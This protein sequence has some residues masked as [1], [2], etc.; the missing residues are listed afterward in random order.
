MASNVYED[1]TPAPDLQ[2]KQLRHLVWRSLFLQ[3]SFNYERMQACGWLYSILPGLRHIHKNKKDLSK[4]MKDNMEFFNTHPFLVTFIM[5]VILAM[6]Q[7]KEDREAIRGIKVATMGPLG[8]IGDALFYL[9]LL[10][11]TAGIGASLAVDG[12]VLGPFVFI[13]AFNVIHFG[14]RFGLM[15]YGYKTGVK[16]IAKLKEG[17]KHVSRAASIVGL[18]VVGGLIATYVAFNVTYVWKSGEA[19]LKVQED[20]L[21]QIMPAMLPLAYTLLMY[22]LLKKGRS[23]LMLIGLTV[24]V[25]LIGSYFKIL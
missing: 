10:P 25:G 20:V 2:P 23:P 3:A 12:N 6:E 16:A 1:Q 22:W 18:T 5:G 19:E 17:T 11:I 14:V 21:D 7:K 24:V 8:G 13:I 15:S 9:T 4:S